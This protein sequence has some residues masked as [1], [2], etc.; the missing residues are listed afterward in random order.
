VVI[1]AA[2]Q[3]L[4][5]GYF[6][7]HPLGT[8]PSQ[9]MATSLQAYRVVRESEAYHRL[10]VVTTSGL[11]PFVGREHELGL[12]MECWEQAQE[13]RGRIAVIRGEAGIGKSRLVRVLQE[14]LAAESP[15]EIVW[16]GAPYNQQSVLQPVMMHLHRLLR[17]RPEEAP[18]A[19]LQRLEAVLASSGLA[20]PEVV[21]LFAALLALPLPARYPPRLLTPQDQRQQTLDALL[22]W[23]LAEAARH[24][25]LFI[26]EDLHWMDPSTLEFLSLLIDQAPTARL[27]LVLTS[28]P[29]FHPSWGF[30]THLTPI[31]LGH[32][33]PRQAAIMVQRM[34]GQALPPAVQQHLVAHTDGVPL[35]IEEVT[36]LVLESDLLQAHADHDAL[37]GSLPALAIPATLHDT[38]M[39]RLDRLAS[40]KAVAQLGA[41]IGRSFPYDVLQA[42]SPWEETALQH[43]LRQLVEAELVYQRGVP[44]QATYQ[45]KHALIRETA[46]Q[47][48]LTSTRQQYHQQIAQ[49]LET[50][51]PGICAMQPEL[52]AHHYTEADVL[53][54]AMPYWQRAG[55][56]AIERSA[57]VEAISHLTKGLALLTSLPDTAARTQHELAFLTTLGPALMATKG[58]AAPEV[59]QA[60]TR[61][62]ELCQQAGETPEHFLVLYNLWVF[63]VIRAEHLTTL[64]LGEQCLQLAHRVQDET[65]LLMA[66]F[67]L[68]ASWFYRGRP[69]LACTY[70]EHMMALYAPAQHHVL[71]YHYGGFDPGIMGW[72]YYAWALWLR[73][74]PAQARAHSAK[75][76][77]LAQQLA[78]PY[79]LARTLYYDALLGQLRRDASAVRDQAD[80]VITVATVQRFALMQALGPIMRG[81]AITVQE[82]S[83]EGLVQIRQGLEM[84]RSTGA[85]AQRPYLL[86]LLAE[87]SGLLDQPD[88]GLV[89]LDEALTLLEQTGERYYEAELH[90]QRGALLLL[91][92]EKSHPAQSSREQHDAE[93]CLQQALDVSRRQEAKALELRAA[94][95]LSRLWQRQGKRDEA[96]ALLVPIYGWF[97]EG[98]DTADLQE[99]KA[100]LETLAG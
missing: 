42:V 82:H 81:W 85:E 75:A 87:A 59:V 43:G 45:F 65:L 77:S 92:A 98:F 91:R 46:Y 88:G 84:Y 1:S 80:A 44:P 50:R 100:L 15:T 78:H 66:H 86:T 90:R 22:A 48:L 70:L 26:V 95:S 64:A 4:I 35:F 23:L 99:A 57:N 13:G 33:S 6:L 10:D 12:L 31:T 36:K 29:E 47:S 74:Y 71:A 8:P 73:G 17:V 19:L 76:L 41:V 18:A 7:C 79:T 27:L 69:A 39:A 5:H 54:Q 83:P 89:A 25:V 96:R 60:Y 34:A 93:T 51:F 37:S 14:H 2:T 97:T 61:A 11:T 32:L 24:P 53:A 58:Y 40:S 3:R 62:R 9:E 28:R 63:Y 72:L 68:G 49:A 30:R 56:R 52:L 16:R 94:V 38:L 67:M 55:Q 20:L 21:P